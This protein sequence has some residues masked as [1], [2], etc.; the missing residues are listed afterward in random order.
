[1]LEGD[2]AM[3]TT[4]DEREAALCLNPRTQKQI[5]RFLPLYPLSVSLPLLWMDSIRS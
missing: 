5:L 1:M 3:A 2:Q 4:I